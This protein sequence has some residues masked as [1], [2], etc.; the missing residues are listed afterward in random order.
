MVALGNH[1][2]G[3]QWYGIEI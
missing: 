1:K 3:I 2:R